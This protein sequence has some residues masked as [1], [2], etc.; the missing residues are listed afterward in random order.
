MSS[1]ALAEPHP[2]ALRATVLARPSARVAL[3]LLCALAT[4]MALWQAVGDAPST[5]EPLYVTDGLAALERHDLRLNPQHPPLA[6]ALA[7]LPVLLAHPALPSGF[8]R[9][10]GRP[11]SRA[12]VNELY[13]DH[14]LHEVTVLARLVPVL[15]LAL[16]VLAVYA[17]ARRL[18]GPAGGLFAAALWA[19]DPFVIGLG[20]VDGI[21][22]PAT[23]IALG[24]CLA[25]VRWMERRT[26][27]R[28][29]TIGAAC[30]AAL[31][32]RDTGPLLV[33]VGVIS[34]GVAARDLRPAIVVSALAYAVVWLVYGAL[35][36]AYTLHHLT[37][38]PQRYLDGLA[39]LAALH[40]RPAEAFLLGHHYRGGRWWYYGA[41]MVIKLPATLLLSYA[42]ALA[43]LRRVP[44]GAGRRV[45]L[46]V[47]PSALALLVFTV[48]TPVNLGL[49]YL[50]PVLA[51][52]TVCVAPL[53]HARRAL[54][55]LLV[56]GSA[57]FTIASLPHSTAWVSPPFDPGYRVVTADN[58]DWG[59]DA[60]RL[61]QWARGK[62]AWVGCYS[63]W[64]R[65]AQV[66]PG[67]RALRKH[68][69]RSSVHGWLG[70]SASLVYLHGWD[71]WLTR[72]QPVGTLGGTELLYRVA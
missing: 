60:F 14:Q 40:R 19:L 8:D 26:P 7:A 67:A 57:A 25:L 58:L 35:D 29:L 66:I 16:T 68:T 11:Y 39:R 12:F 13:R 15:E 2:R 20:H 34:V 4:G 31:V 28:L 55:V 23:V 59:Q 1:T 54:P 71:P 52:I 62:D 70:I 18:A 9:S 50:L 30:G 6:K 63:P 5:D 36:P 42:L 47:L 32:V 17:L 49:R 37:V 27:G 45:L 61:Q 53:V 43:F 64:R 10:R 56:A 65:C 51:L 69:A 41:S 3:A 46:A 21:D 72:L 38:L 48:A 24:L 44:S 22:L 33:A